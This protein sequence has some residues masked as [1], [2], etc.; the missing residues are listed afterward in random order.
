LRQKK[1]LELRE[2]E[3][4]RG[5]GEAL[6]IESTVGGRNEEERRIITQGMAKLSLI[7]QQKK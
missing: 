4:R 5:W 1:I 6:G 2:E 7:F 3:E